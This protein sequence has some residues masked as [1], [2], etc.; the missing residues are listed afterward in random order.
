VSIMAE[1]IQRRHAVGGIAQTFSVES[2]PAAVALAPSEAI[3]PVCGMSVT[4]EGAKYTYEHE[5]QVYYFCCPGCRKSFANEP[6]QYFV[7]S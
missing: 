5:G 7:K 2:T 3:D 4:I 1:I 6:E